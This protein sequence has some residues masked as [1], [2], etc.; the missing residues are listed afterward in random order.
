[1]LFSQCP[2]NNDINCVSELKQKSLFDFLEIKKPIYESSII[3]VLEHS[4]FLPKTN[5]NYHQLQNRRYIGNKQK[6]INWIFSII[7][8]DCEN[9]NTFTDIFAGTGI[10]SSIAL[11]EYKEVIINDFLYSNNIIYKA[12][13]EQKSF[14]EDKINNIIKNYNN[15]NPNDL[16]DNYFSKN[17]GDKY[18]SYNSAKIIGFIRENIEEN[19]ENLT[20]KEYSILIASL[21][22]SVDKI[23]NTVGHYDAYFKKQH[24]EDKFFLKPIEPIKSNSNITIYQEDANLLAKKIKTDIVYIDPP[25]NSRQYSRFYHVL[26]NLT[27]WNKPQ[28]YGVALKPKPENMSDYC[29]V[30]AK[31]KLY[32]LVHTIDTKYFAVSYNNTY[33]S[34]S[35]SSKNKITLEEIKKILNSVGTTNIYEKKHQEFNT[36]KTEFN[37]HREYLFITKVENGKN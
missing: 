24:I 16:E 20:D 6:L 1:M 22:Y 4:Y 19:K 21:L 13:F 31:K 27:K 36:G 23:A 26:E 9:I 7:K 28:L 2:N 15:I 5:N 10:V 17:F 30:S 3:K 32:E 8:K 35:N 11:N 29:R 14:N 37:N 25:Y 33:N 34:K 18:F 12:F